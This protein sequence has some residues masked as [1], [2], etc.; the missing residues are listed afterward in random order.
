VRRYSLNPWCFYTDITDFY[1]EAGE[2]I[3][4]RLKANLA[5]L[6]EMQ[7]W[8]NPAGGR[9]LACRPISA[10]MGLNSGGHSYS[11]SLIW[12]LPGFLN[13]IIAIAYN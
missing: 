3:G 9:A 1:T 7:W 10:V 12:G 4:V 5:W 8:L 11:A 2:R 13:Y 6:A